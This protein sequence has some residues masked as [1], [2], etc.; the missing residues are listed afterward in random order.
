MLPPLDP[1]GEN[2]LVADLVV[3]QERTIEILTN[4]LEVVLDWLVAEK[5]KY[6]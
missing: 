2:T 6:N 5:Q 1:E 4:A 3:K